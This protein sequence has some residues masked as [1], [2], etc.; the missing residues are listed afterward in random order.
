MKKTSKKT[1]TRKPK[2]DLKKNEIVELKLYIAGH[3]QRSVSALANLKRVCS[4][5]LKGKHHIEVI[6]LLV[7][8]QMAR[9]DHIFAIPTLVRTNPMP[10][11]KIIGDLSDTDKLV[12]GLNIKDIG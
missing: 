11:R 1:P 10:I 3:T 7:N 2:V 6:D 8:P 4:K 12:A 5:Y 9:E